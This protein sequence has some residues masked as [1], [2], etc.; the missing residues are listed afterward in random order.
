MGRNRKP[1]KYLELT[2]AFRKNP[3]RRRESEPVCD[4]PVGPTPARLTDHQAEAWNYLVDSAADVPGVLT[5]LDRA[6]LELCS[7][8]LAGVW[9][10][11][12]GENKKPISVHALKTV[13]SMLGNLGMSPSDR[14]R[15]TVVEPKYSGDDDEFRPISRH[16]RNSE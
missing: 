16:S 15:L 9:E 8:A 2:D 7:I 4:E 1:T 3:K 6:Y 5:R 14:T 12:A 11:N 10:Y 13:G